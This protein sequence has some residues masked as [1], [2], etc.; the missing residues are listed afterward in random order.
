MMFGKC[1]FDEAKTARL[2]ECL[3]RYRRD[4]NSRTGAET[5]P[6]HDEFSHGA[7][8]F[9]Y[10]AQALPLMGNVS[11]YRYSEHCESDWRVL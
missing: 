10:I 9:R 4:T 1:Y 8:M 6:L 11:E 5:K 7:D 3:K 2:V